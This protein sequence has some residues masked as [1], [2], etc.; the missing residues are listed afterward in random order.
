MYRSIDVDY[1]RD[2]V[3]C[4]PTGGF[5]AG[6]ALRAT[7]GAVVTL[8]PTDMPSPELDPQAFE[9]SYSLEIMGVAYA[10][11]S[12]IPG[13]DLGIECY[14]PEP[15]SACFGL[16]SLPTLGPKAFGTPWGPYWMDPRAGATVLVGMDTSGR[17]GVGRIR[18]AVSQFAPDG[19]VAACQV[20][21]MGPTT[22]IRLS[23]PVFPVQ[24]T[25]YGSGT[26]F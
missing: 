8:S 26:S 15:L 7:G 18:S 5:I 13:F 1:G 4:A 17:T 21:F 10:H 24:F 3:C 9:A 2:S 20:V 22:G 23:N 11:M 19:Q 14:S 25:R 12:A 16:V 6:P